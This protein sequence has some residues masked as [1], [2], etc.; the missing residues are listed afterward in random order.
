[1]VAGPLKGEAPQGFAFLAS[2]ALASAALASAVPASADL[3][4]ALLEPA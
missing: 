3:V 1:M 4:S 2:V